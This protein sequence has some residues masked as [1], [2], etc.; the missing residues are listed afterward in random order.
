MICI[1]HGNEDITVGKIIIHRSKICYGGGKNAGYKMGVSH[2]DTGEIFAVSDLIPSVEIKDDNNLF[3]HIISPRPELQTFTDEDTRKKFLASNIVVHMQRNGEKFEEKFSYQLSAIGTEEAIR[4]AGEN[5]VLLSSFNRFIL[6]SLR[7]N[8]VISPKFLECTD[9][10]EADGVKRA[11]FAIPIPGSYDMHLTC[12]P[13]NI[14]AVKPG[15][16]LIGVI[17]ENGN[18]IFPVVNFLTGEE[19]NV[20]AS[21]TTCE[22]ELTIDGLI[23]A[24]T[25]EEQKKIRD[26]ADIKSRLL[27]RHLDLN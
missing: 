10:V 22:G 7:L 9:F 13:D 20:T 3:V 8:K 1:S 5:A 23:N 18:Y 16:Y 19:Y 27:K 17:D 11:S 25:A 21:N 15:N 2:S 24:V 26:L 4:D 14:A 6:Y 12:T